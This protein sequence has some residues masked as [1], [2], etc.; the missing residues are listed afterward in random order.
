ML[1]VHRVRLVM[2]SLCCTSF[3]FFFSSRRRHT[4]CALVTGV[5]TCALPISFLPV[6]EIAQVGRQLADTLASTRR[7]RLVHDEP[8]RITDGPQ[9]PPLQGKGL[10]VQFRQLGFTYGG[11]SEPALDGIDLNVDVGATL[12]LEIGRA[13]V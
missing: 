2:Y 9:N 7:L 8:V 1:P 12:A 4:R 3:A 5:Q 13:H 11:R 10:P 6:S